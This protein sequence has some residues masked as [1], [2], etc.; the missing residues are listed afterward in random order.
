MGNG[1]KSG[2][3]SRSSAAFRGTLAAV[4]TLLGGGFRFARIEFPLCPEGDYSAPGLSASG[5]F[6]SNSGFGSPMPRRK[7]T[8][9]SANCR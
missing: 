9:F 1:R 5:F 7:R 2:I 3:S 4:F 6:P 8:P